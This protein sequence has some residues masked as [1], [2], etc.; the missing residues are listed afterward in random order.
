MSLKR[1]VEEL[2]KEKMPAK[3]YRKNKAIDQ[4]GLHKRPQMEQIIDYLANGQERVK[5]PD[6]E[7]SQIRN[8]PYMTQLD[9]VD[10]QEEQKKA[11]EDQVTKQE[12]KT[13]S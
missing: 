12:A 3:G 1:N 9:F 10:M 6:R 11:W 2:V 5:F 13:R 4:T 8:H 7:A